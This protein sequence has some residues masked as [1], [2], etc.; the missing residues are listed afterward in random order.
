MHT[1]LLPI[2]TRLIST[3]G[4]GF[5]ATLLLIQPSTTL[6]K[7]SLETA[8]SWASYSWLA[9]TCNKTHFASSTYHVLKTL[10]LRYKANCTKQVG[11]IFCLKW[12]EQEDAW[13]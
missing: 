12:P 2:E 10:R 11:R 7:G 9:K 1:P 4:G 5:S 3:I 6:P 13:R 8:E